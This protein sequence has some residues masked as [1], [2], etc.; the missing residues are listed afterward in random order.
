[1]R[2]ALVPLAVWIPNACRTDNKTKKNVVLSQVHFNTVYV[3]I[4]LFS[5]V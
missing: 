2:S 1:M 5:T 3:Y 4:V